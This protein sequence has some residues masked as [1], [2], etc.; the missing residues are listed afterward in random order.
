[1]ARDVHYRH[2]VGQPQLVQRENLRVRADQAGGAIDAHSEVIPCP[3]S[4]ATVGS[5]KPGGFGFIHVRE[6]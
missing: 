4:W 1:M 2:V 6:S 3:R 5:G